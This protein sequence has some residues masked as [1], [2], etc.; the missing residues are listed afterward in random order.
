[1]SI[2]SVRTQHRC[3]KFTSSI[4]AGSVLTIMS[5]AGSSPAKLGERA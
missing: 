5:V 4:V 3:A 1:M 2:D